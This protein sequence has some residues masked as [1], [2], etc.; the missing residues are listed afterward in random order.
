MWLDER[1]S[2]V[3]HYI[4]AKVLYVTKREWPEIYPTVQFLCTSIS[5]GRLCRL[6]VFLKGTINGK[7]NIGL[8]NNE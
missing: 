3:F 1:R 6:L 4:N 2:E 8:K 7:Q 5:K